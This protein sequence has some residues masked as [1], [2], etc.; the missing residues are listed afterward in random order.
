MS[1]ETV[2]SVDVMSRITSDPAIFEGKPIIRGKQLAVEHV[3]GMLGGGETL[4]SMQKMYPWLE[5]ADLRAC[6]MFARRVLGQWK[7]E[8]PKK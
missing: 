8:M 4:E 1:D 7:I 3:L 2:T 6:F 5:E